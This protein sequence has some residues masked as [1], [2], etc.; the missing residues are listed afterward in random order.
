MNQQDKDWTSMV[1]STI[2]RAYELGKKYERVYRGCSQSAVAALQDAFNIKNA[3]VFKAATGL[4]GGCGSATDGSCGAYV[5]GIMFASCLVGREREKFNDT[6]GVRFRTFD[7]ARKLH[8]KFIEAYGSVICRDIHTKLMGRP[9]YL[10]DAEEFEKFEKAGAH[11]VH[12][13][14]VVGSAARWMA[15]I[16]LSEGLANPRVRHR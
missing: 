16:I 13:V 5:G 2:E 4:A 3:D 10:P 8:D 15:D 6:E 7:L 9:F 14:E 12:C 1:E 11:T